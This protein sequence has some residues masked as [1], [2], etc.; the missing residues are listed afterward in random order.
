MNRMAMALVLAVAAACAKGGGDASRAGE[1]VADGFEDGADVAPVPD[2]S[3]AAAK[4]LD[5]ACVGKT[6]AN[7]YPQCLAYWDAAR[8][9]CLATSATGCDAWATRQVEQACSAVE[10][11][12]TAG[13]GP[14]EECAVERDRM[15]SGCG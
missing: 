5:V 6:T 12:P 10:A 7:S 3:A 1:G 13:I 11:N 2:A 15:S 4:A 8:A 9:C 14:D